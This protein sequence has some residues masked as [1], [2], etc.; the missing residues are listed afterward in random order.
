MCKVK[1]LVIKPAYHSLL[2]TTHIS[3]H[4]DMVYSFAC[5]V[6]LIKQRR[7]QSSLGNTFTAFCPF[8]NKA[9]T[10]SLKEALASESYVNVSSMSQ[11]VLSLG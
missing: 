7:I 5:M 10:A 4:S 6:P 3:Y 9:N 2:L 11:T 1:E 8:F